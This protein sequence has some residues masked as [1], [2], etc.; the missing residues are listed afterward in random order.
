MAIATE[1]HSFAFSDNVPHIF[2]L[3]C[4]IL[5]HYNADS[6]DEGLMTHD[7]RALANHFLQLAKLEARPLTHLHM[8]KILYF[9]HGYHLAYYDDPLFTQTVQAWKHGPVIPEVYRAFRGFGKFPITTPAD[10]HDER[11]ECTPYQAELSPI[12]ARYLAS[13]W[14]SYKVISPYKLSDMSHAPDG[15]WAQVSAGQDLDTNRGV[16]IPNTIIREY[17]VRLVQKRGGGG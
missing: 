4:G 8:Q 12:T 6:S 17:F 10:T 9:G 11:F 15:P 13:V 7:A 5:I 2:S 1:S 16:P 3:G 14:D